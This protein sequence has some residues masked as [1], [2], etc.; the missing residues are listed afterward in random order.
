[1]WRNQRRPSIRVL[2]YKTRKTRRG[3]AGKASSDDQVSQV[4]KEERDRQRERECES[5]SKIDPDTPF[6]THVCYMSILPLL[7]TR[8]NVDV[9]YLL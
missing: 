7:S 8:L 1:M 6:Y 5:P 3:L 9:W 4:S 2:A